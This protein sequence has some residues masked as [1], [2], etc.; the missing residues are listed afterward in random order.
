MFRAFRPHVGIVNIIF[1]DFHVNF[2]IP[3]TFSSPFLPLEQKIDEI[4]S[5]WKVLMHA[6]QIS[7]EIQ[8]LAIF[9]QKHAY[10]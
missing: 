4:F 9:C 2:R 3:L 7:I 5:F 10:T 6:I 1:K 8:E